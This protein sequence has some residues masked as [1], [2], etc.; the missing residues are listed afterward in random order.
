M[1]NNNL[2]KSL[3]YYKYGNYPKVIRLLEPDVFSYREND[4][5]YY[6]LGSSCLFTGD[7]SGANSYLRRSLQINPVNTDT[8]LSL[9][10][11]HL[12]RGSSKEAIQIWL[13]VLDK[14]PE[15]RFAKRGLNLLKKSGV[16]DGFSDQF[17]K[18]NMNSL[19]P[20][21]GMVLLNRIFRIFLVI[22]LAFL[23]ISAL[24]FLSYKSYF[25]IKNKNSQIPEITLKNTDKIVSTG[26][27]ELDL[28]E[29]EI[30]RSFD[31]A[32]ESFIDN[33]TNETQIEINR[34]I[35]SNAS[36]GVKDK[37]RL[38][39]SY[40]EKPDFRYFKNTI[41]YREV[42]E[43]PFLFNNCYIK[44]KGK[45]TNIKVMEKNLEFDFLIG[46][47]DGRILEGIIG[48]DVDFPILL[49]EDFSYEII[50]QL[51]TAGNF[52]IQALSLRK[53]LQ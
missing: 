31:R 40:L 1:K 10:V 29:K 2:K 16:P 18:K 5:Y 11:I 43:K 25:Y 9:A 52:R 49:E 46:Y 20:G 12:K 17:I 45:I 47:E 3:K 19:I 44:W 48:V 42:V 27:F 36:E 8:M 13:D 7:Y 22:L 53:F 34:I 4:R 23:I 26:N 39:E 21:R 33:N 41:S 15:N 35:N 28:S 24:S 6:L 14:H 37:T 32:R 30:I 50:G 38:L 51:H